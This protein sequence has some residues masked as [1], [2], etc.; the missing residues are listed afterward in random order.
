MER[1]WVQ[2]GYH[3]SAPNAQHLLISAILVSMVI[4][5]SFL[6]PSAYETKLQNPVS[7]G[8]A[9]VYNDCFLVSVFK[10]LATNLSIYNHLFCKLF[11]QF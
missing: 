2:P 8:L 4:H 3:V 7:E 9:E 1:I 10:D 5:P 11:L 6:C